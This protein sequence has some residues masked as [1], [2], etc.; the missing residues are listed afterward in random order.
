MYILGGT[1]NHTLHVLIH[2]FT[3]WGGH[4]N[5]NVNKAFAIFSNIPFGIPSAISFGKYH[6]DHHNYLGEE[7]KDPDLPTDFEV[8]IG[9]GP[10]AKILFFIFLSPIYALRPFV[11]MHK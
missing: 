10:I 5:I 3:H 7:G 1:I 11:L 8:S 2:D 6:S 4:K 9:K